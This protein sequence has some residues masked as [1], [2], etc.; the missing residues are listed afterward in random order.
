[1]RDCGF[2]QLADN[3]KWSLFAVSAQAKEPDSAI[4]I[5]NCRFESRGG[6]MSL[7][8]DAGENAAPNLILEGCRF[9]APFTQ[10]YATQSVRRLRLAG[11][12]FVGGTN[13]INLN[14]NAWS[15]A[16]RVEIANNTFVGTKYWLGFVTSFRGNTVPTGQT[17]S[18]VCNN[19]ILGGERVQAG[20]DQLELA[21]NTWRFSANWWE[22]DGT[23]MSDAGWGG[24]L[25]QMHPRL[26][27][28]PFRDPQHPKF[29]V[30]TAGSPLLTSGCGGKLPSHI[31][32]NGPPP[33]Q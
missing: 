26:D 7:S 1:M 10:V 3:S 6:A 33:T 27:D 18:L 19:L 20:P 2:S 23:T 4:R 29:L 30:P 8:A 9:S 25:A 13:A 22:Q 15:S 12:V 21:L 16:S 17:D 5:E 24:R 14:I 28:V 31:G 11:N 32:A